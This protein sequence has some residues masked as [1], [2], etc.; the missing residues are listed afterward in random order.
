M[1]TGNPKLS[2]DFINGLCNKHDM[3]Y[4]DVKNWIFCGGRAGHANAPSKFISYEKYFT[5]CFPNTEFPDI[6][7]RCVCDAELVHNCY[8]R[9]D[10]EAT[11]DT[12]LI[13][14]SCCIDKFIDAGKVKKCERCASDHRNRNDNICKTCRN[15]QNE[16]EKI[17]RKKQRELDTYNR[18]LDKKIKELEEKERLLHLGRLYLDIPYYISS[19][20]D[21]YGTLKENRCK[22]D[23]ELVAWYCNG[24]ERQRNYIIEVFQKYYIKDIEDFKKK[25]NDKHKEYKSKNYINELMGDNNIPFKMAVTLAKNE[26]HKW[27]DEQKLWYK[28]Y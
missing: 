14:G 2:K 15:R 6:D 5:Q 27:D 16:L 11:A 17:E 24:N 26:G 7:N 9:K 20:T 13:V 19:M 4:D 22:W 28:Q 8:I 25:R 3:S 10:I 21:N 1:T 23:S 18:R 12:I